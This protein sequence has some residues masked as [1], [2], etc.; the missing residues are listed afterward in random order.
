MANHL[1]ADPQRDRRDRPV[2]H[3]SAD[4]PRRPLGQP[5]A[6]LVPVEAPLVVP[7]DERHRRERQRQADYVLAG[8]SPIVTDFGQGS[9]ISHNQANA[10]YEL[11]QAALPRPAGLRRRLGVTGATPGIPIFYTLRGGA[12]KTTSAT[13][14][15]PAAAASSASGR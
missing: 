9:I 3:G 13:I 12:P 11:R 2:R 8:T 4:D 5:R 6:A 1:P 7:R 14:S 15:W 10:G